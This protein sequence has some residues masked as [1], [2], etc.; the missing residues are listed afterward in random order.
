MAILRITL[1]I[2]FSFICGCNKKDGVISGKHTEPLGGF[3]YIPP[4]GWNILEWPGY[5]YKIAVDNPKKGFASNINIVDAK[6]DGATL[7]LCVDE[8]NNFAKNNL[9]EMKILSK[10]DFMTTKGL[11]MIKTVFTMKEKGLIMRCMN[12]ATKN[13]D[14][15]IVITAT[16]LDEEAHT[17]ETSINNCL[18]SFEIE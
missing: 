6:H 7:D 12:Y 8:S 15:V 1:I 16:M 18:K 14:K 10:E 2:C 11:R 4:E 3:S 5:K 17:V 9:S 13:K